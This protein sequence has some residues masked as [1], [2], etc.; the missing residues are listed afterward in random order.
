MFQS[1]LINT[2]LTIAGLVLGLSSGGLGGAALGVSLAYCLHIVTIYFFLLR[3]LLEIRFG[4]L[5]AFASEIAAAIVACAACAV[6]SP[7]MVDW[8]VAFSGVVKLA[9]VAATVFVAY[10]LTGQF[11]E[12]VKLFNR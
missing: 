12:F 1:G 6:L 10:A 4:D 3:D 9:I 5:S 2:L 7:F 8:S 11:K